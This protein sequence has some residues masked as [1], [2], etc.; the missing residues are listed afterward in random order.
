MPQAPDSK[1]NKG[2]RPSETDFKGKKKY[3]SEWSYLVMNIPASLFVSRKEF[4]YQQLHLHD[5]CANC[6]CGWRQGKASN[7][8]IHVDLSEDQYQ[9]FFYLSPKRNYFCYR[10]EMNNKYYKYLTLT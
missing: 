1:S 5:S 3:S 2:S 7:L 4:A 9:I 8:Q 10:Q 6:S